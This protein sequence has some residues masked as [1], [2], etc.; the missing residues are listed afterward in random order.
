M[1]YR[2]GYYPV[3]AVKASGSQDNSGIGFLS[4]GSHTP[5]HVEEKELM[6]VLVAPIMLGALIKLG[7]LGRQEGTAFKRLES[8]GDGL[9]GGGCL[10]QQSLGLLQAGRLILWARALAK[11]LVLRCTQDPV[12]LANILDQG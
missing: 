8:L 1:H 7:A 5:N 6:T 11:G 9:G 12:L 3:C 4:S 2:L 10:G